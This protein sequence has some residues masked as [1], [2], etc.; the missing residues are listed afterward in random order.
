MPYLCHDSEGVRHRRQG[1]LPIHV[2]RADKQGKPTDRILS[3]IL[4]E[5]DFSGQ[6]E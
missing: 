6:T 4:L 3:V 2:A 5:N 1:S